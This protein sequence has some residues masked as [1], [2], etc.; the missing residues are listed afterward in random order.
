MQT[1]SSCR[2]TATNSQAQNN[3]GSQVVGIQ[4]LASRNSF[5]AEGMGLERMTNYSKNLCIAFSALQNPVQSNRNWQNCSLSGQICV[6]RSSSKLCDLLDLSRHAND[7]EN[8][9]G[10]QSLPLDVHSPARVLQRRRGWRP[11]YASLT[12]AA[13]QSE[14]RPTIPRSRAGSY[15]TPPGYNSCQRSR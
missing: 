2:Q 14:I 4:P 15:L 3:V 6:K 7:G 1:S 5:T 9:D 13:K 11:M 8:L 10:I 12:D